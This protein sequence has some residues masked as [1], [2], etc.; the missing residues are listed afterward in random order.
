MDPTGSGYNVIQSEISIGSGQFA[1]KGY[2]M[3]SQN[4]LEYLPAKHT[5]F[6]FATI[7]EE[8]GFIGTVIVVSLLT[9]IIIRCIYVALKAGDSYGS[10]ICIGVGAMLAF[11]MLENIG[12]CIQLMPVTG[13]PL[14]FFSYGGS[15]LLTNLM[16]VGFVNSVSSRCRGINFPG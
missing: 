7:G 3:G 1:G 15:S 8:W 11:H 6:I 9:L 10:Y 13:I 5:D 16:A 12:M 4:Q 14:P 2:L